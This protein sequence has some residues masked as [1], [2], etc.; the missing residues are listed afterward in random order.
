MN[1]N[2]KS[3]M[4]WLWIV[5]IGV[6]A[7]FALGYIKLP[8]G[9]SGITPS[10]DGSCQ[11]APTVSSVVVDGINTGTSVSPSST[12]TRVNGIYRGS[13]MPS[14]LAYG[15]EGEAIFSAPNYIDQKYS[16]GPLGC[17]VNVLN[18]KLYATD[19]STIKVFNDIGDVVIDNIAGGATNQ[20]ASSTV[21][22][23]EVKI[24]ANADQTSGDLVCVIEA[25]NTSQVDRM[26]L[27]GAT[28]VSVPEFYSV[29]GAGS[30]AEA[31]EIPAL[32]DGA[33]KTYNLKISPES[34][35]T[36]DGTG[37]YFTCYS[38]QWFVD[39]DGTFVYGIENN[40]GA[41]EYEDTFDYDWMIA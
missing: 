36:I 41:T 30:V 40:D 2:G 16:F 35:Q 24:I 22:D 13:S 18:G 31:Y 25:T 26:I 20:S 10:A 29:A 4:S 15:D 6:V 23:Q 27:S 14:T 5:I 34:G 28:K 17:G 12:Y 3:N 38:K 8:A 21:I 1:K 19:A 33:S 11:L 7:L 37:I 9:S 39:T 32:V